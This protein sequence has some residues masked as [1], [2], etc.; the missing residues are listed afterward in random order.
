MKILRLMTSFRGTDSLSFQ[1]GNAIVEKISTQYPD[2]EISVMNL[3]KDEL[4][5]LNEI[6]FTSFF[7]SP[8]E[9]STDLLHAISF[10]NNSIKELLMADILVIDVPMYNFSIP[11]SLK[12]WIDHVVRAGVTFRY[13]ENGVEGLVKDKKVFLAISSGGVYSEGPMKEF[14]LTERY[15]RNI[16]GFIGITDIT[17]FRVEGSAIPALKDTALPKALQ[18]VE[19]YSL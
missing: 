2:T 15:L 11:S 14:D 16:L 4:P 3:A 7:S 17:T 1:L 13:T 19:A 9:L 10:S 12:A 6:H 8:D 5:H 18:M